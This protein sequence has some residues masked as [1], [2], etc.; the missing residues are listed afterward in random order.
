[1]KEPALPSAEPLLQDLPDGV[2]APVQ[3]VPSVGF[4]YLALLLGAVPTALLALAQA[5]A[6]RSARAAGVAA[7]TAVVALLAPLVVF[8]LGADLVSNLGLLLLPAR[9]L[10][11]GL[12]FLLHRSQ[13][14]PIRAHQLLGGA[15]V[16]LRLVVLPAFVAMFLLP[17]RAALLLEFP[18]L[19]L[20][21]LR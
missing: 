21:E 17:G 10:A 9:I 13:V 2:R 7:L 1:M 12:G 16:E 8:A 3:V 14:A 15:A 4:V 19:L 11:I 6:L 18:I 20:G 5:L